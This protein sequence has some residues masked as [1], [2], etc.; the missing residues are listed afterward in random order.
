MNSSR[1][2]ALSAYG[3]LV[4][5]LTEATPDVFAGR[6]SELTDLLSDLKDLLQLTLGEAASVPATPT[7]QSS[8]P[9]EIL[10]SIDETR[11]RMIGVLLGSGVISS[12]S[13]V[14]SVDLPSVG[15]LVTGRSGITHGF[16]GD[17]CVILMPH[18]ENA[19]IAEQLSPDLL[20]IF[21][22]SRSSKGWIV[23]C[24]ALKQL[25]FSA[26]ATLLAYFETF[27]RHGKEMHLVWLPKRALPGN[28]LG[29]VQTLF[30]L[31]L[32]GEFLFTRRITSKL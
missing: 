10:R 17:R 22:A 9:Q 6:E 27:E 28:M 20:N 4:S 26:L 11:L 2:A 31:E 29:R 1:T 8:D 5:S 23:D 21:D 13:G 16:L 24:S 19:S 3:A 32:V 14:P 25:P 30:N 15:A 12:E 18:I 7:R